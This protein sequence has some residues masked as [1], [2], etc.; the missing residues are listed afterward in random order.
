MKAIFPMPNK[1]VIRENSDQNV[2]KKSE[3]LTDE[4][5]KEKV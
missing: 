4:K 3:K 5:K 2:T 1:K